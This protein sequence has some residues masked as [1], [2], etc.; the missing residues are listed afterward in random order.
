MWKSRNHIRALSRTNRRTA[1]F[2]EVDQV[3]PRVASGLEVRAE[4]RQVVPGR[5]EMVVDDVE[6]HRQATGVT[7]VHEALEPV[8]TAQRF[9]Y[10]V[11]VDPVVAPVPDAVDGVDRHHL[12]VGDA[13]ARPGGRA[14]RWPNRR[15]AR[16]ER[17]DV[18][19]V[20]HRGAEVA[21]PPVGV[22]PGVGVLVVDPARAVDAFRLPA[23]RRIGHRVR[24]RHP[25]GTRSRCRAGSS[26]PAH[27]PSSAVSRSVARPSTTSCTRSTFGAHTRIGVTAQTLPYSR[28]GET[29]AA[30]AVAGTTRTG[31]PEPLRPGGHPARP[32]RPQ[33]V[34]PAPPASRPAR[35]PPAPALRRRCG[36]G[37]EPPAAA[38]AAGDG[39]LRQGWRHRPCRRTPAGR[40]GS[41]TPHSRRRPRRSRRTTSCG[42]S[43]ASYPPRAWSA[44]STGRTTRT[45]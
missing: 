2:L 15:C 8:R 39:H 45:C 13:E 23:R 32:C 19:L 33:R 3:A 31:R 44:C 10:R 1:G 24:V 6:D 42:G 20:D 21:P 26:G 41:G 30:P 29:V 40:A 38:R 9:V 36:R 27:Q 22:V 18:Q 35:A 43:G 4:L 25:A 37:L 7:G 34:T 17:R 11:P 5:P 28:P 14:V 16:R 12:D